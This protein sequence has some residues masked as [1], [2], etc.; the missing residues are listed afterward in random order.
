MDALLHRGPCQIIGAALQEQHQFHNCSHDGW[1]EVYIV[2][3]ASVSDANEDLDN[4][5][6]TDRH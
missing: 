5:F 2:C 6:T 1:E 3:K 4:H